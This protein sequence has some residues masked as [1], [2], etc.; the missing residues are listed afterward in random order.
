MSKV[1]TNLV[2][3]N[4]ANVFE[5]SSIGDS[6]P[7]YNILIM[8]PK[9]DKEGIKKLKQAIDEAIEEGKSLWKNKIPTELKKPLRI[10]NGEDYP[11]QEDMY[12][13]TA[14]SA[15]APGVVDADLE[16][17]TDKDSFYSGCWGR[18]SIKF[19][20]YKNKAGGC[21]ITTYLLNVQKIRDDEKLH[22]GFNAKDDFN[23]GF[24]DEYTKKKSDDM[25]DLL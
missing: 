8:V 16:A 10:G 18:A 22:S 1:V 12:L 2:R 25:D 6:E 9:S 20:P 4:F 19:C 21:G 14:R 7:C 13:I 15:Y 17:I 3:F 23:D 11:E 24:G 5:M